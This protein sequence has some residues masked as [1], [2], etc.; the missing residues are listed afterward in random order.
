MCLLG[1]PDLLGFSGRSGISVE[2]LGLAVLLPF[3]HYE[4]SRSTSFFALF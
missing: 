4:S 1:L 2:D 3:L